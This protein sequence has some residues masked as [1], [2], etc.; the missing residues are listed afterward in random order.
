[1]KLV[2]ATVHYVTVGTLEFLMDDNGELFFMEMNTRIQVEH[3]VTEEVTG[4]D[5]IWEQIRLAAGEPL[6]LKQEQIRTEGHAIEVRVNA[7]DPWSLLPSPGRI[8]GYHEPGGPGVR[9]DSAVHEHAFVQPYYDS[10][11]GKLIVHGKN[12]DHAIRRMLGALDEFIVEGIRTSIPL[13]RELINSDA[14]R[15]VDFYVRFIDEWLEARKNGQPMGGP[16]TA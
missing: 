2:K 14:F 16:K 8:T 6:F 1:M 13:Q 12:R 7:E 15:D 11:T 3:P 4:I 10:L 5:L 9:V